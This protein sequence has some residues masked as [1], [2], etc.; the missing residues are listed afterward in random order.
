MQ[1]L[2]EHY[3][4][5]CRLYVRQAQAIDNGESA[6]W[7]ST[8]TETGTF[9]SPTY[10]ESPVVGSKALSAFASRHYENHR[11]AG[12]VGRHWSNGIDIE[13][14]KGDVLTVNLYMLIITTHLATQTVSMRHVSVHDIMLETGSGWRVHERLVTP[15]MAPGIAGDLPSSLPGTD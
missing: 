7:A 15:D 11:N 9:S 3:I 6:K 2:S 1:I 14:K 4:E 10:P 8:F 13:D 5:L 12:L